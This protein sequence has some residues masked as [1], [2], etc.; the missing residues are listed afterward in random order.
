M[1]LDAE[2]CRTPTGLDDVLTKPNLKPPLPAAALFV[3]WSAKPFA[4][5]HVRA[6]KY[7]QIP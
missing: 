1:T 7:S 5:P 6:F 2:A 3:I 4:V